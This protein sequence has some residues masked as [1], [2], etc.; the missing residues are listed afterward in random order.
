MVPLR[1]VEP[2]GAFYIFV[3]IPR[4]LD[5]AGVVKLFATEFK[6]LLVPGSAFGMENH[7]RVSYGSIKPSEVEEVAK[8]LM[9]GFSTV[10][11]LGLRATWST[12]LADPTANGR[13]GQWAPPLMPQEELIKRE[14]AARGR[15]HT[16][17]GHLH[18]EDH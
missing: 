5:E 7:M 6:I 12:L 14:E 10:C 4:S 18:A 13:D 2:N 8:R 16:D 11:S 3:P 9:K 17:D 1:P 15:S